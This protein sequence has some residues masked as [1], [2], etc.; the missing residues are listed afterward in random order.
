V[1]GEAR[2]PAGPV[3]SEEA[4]RPVVLFVGYYIE[5]TRS[6][7]RV[8]SALTRTSGFRSVFWIYTSEKMRCAAE[9][10]VAAQGFDLLHA[11]P[12]EYSS[13]EQVFLNPI[14]G[15]QVKRQANRAIALSV[16]QR[17]KPSAIVC[18]GDPSGYTFLRAA[19]EL[20][21]PSL[22]LQWTEA[23]SPEWHQAWYRAQAKAKDASLPPLRW[24]RRKVGRRLYRL[25][26][27]GTQW[28]VPGKQASLLAVP[29][30][31]YRDM[32]VQAR[33]A[34]EKIRVTGNPQCDEMFRCA[35]LD[36][37]EHARIREML[38][39]PGNAPIAL[40]ALDDF[41][42]SIHLDRRNAENADET[43]LRAIRT[44]LPD[45]VRVVK[46]HPKHGPEHRE[47]VRAVDPA[48]ILAGSEIEVGSLVAVAA[49]VVCVTSSVLLWAVGIGRPAIS[50]FLWK[51]ADEFRMVRHYFGVEEADSYDALAEALRRQTSDPE[52]IG[53]WQ[54]KRRL[55]RDR[56]LRVDG[57][58]VD[59]IVAEV[60][61]LVRETRT[62]RV[63]RGD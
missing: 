8:A 16:L 12:S 63:A 25:L 14:R 30:E 27:E 1:R 18:T 9:A 52:H 32:Y 21:I 44:A 19:N 40:F 33:V 60:S 31:F 48:A 55:C 11:W 45:Y 39:I 49:A 56:F 13:G 36:E 28:P 26:G 51:G 46:L 62:G 34:Q 35:N 47:R 10:A 2:V 23:F 59:R 24:L 29:G 50:A 61:G 57:K 3:S 38:G 53:V 6:L 42:R 5:D 7:C 4:H 43:I 17:V 22:Y 41:E 58:S 15:V 54:E 37:T 20:R